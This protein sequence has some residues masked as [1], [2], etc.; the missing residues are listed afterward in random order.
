MAPLGDDGA[1][2]GDEKQENREKSCQLM[3][4]VT[5]MKLLRE[6]VQ[7]SLLMNSCI[8]FPFCRQLVKN[9]SPAA[10]DAEKSSPQVSA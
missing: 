4:R 1:K 2:P 3:P 7:R 8:H 6:M 10:F 9:R 5:L